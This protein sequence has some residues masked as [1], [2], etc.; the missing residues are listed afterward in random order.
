M[1][2]DLNQAIQQVA[3]ALGTTVDRVLSVVPSYAQMQ[4]ARGLFGVAVSAVVC[5]ACAVGMRLALGA[6]D[7]A[8]EECNWS[9]FEWWDDSEGSFIAF[10]ACAAFFV[11][12][13]VLALSNVWNALSW[14]QWPDAKVAEMVLG[15]VGNG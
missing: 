4:V 14:A 6:R 10:V 13:V 11:F 5:V 12:A 3:D 8:R 1:T 9:P 7:R 2:G 15:M